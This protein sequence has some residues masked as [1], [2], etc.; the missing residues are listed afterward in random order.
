MSDV[1]PLAL[2]GGGPGRRAALSGPRGA[3]EAVMLFGELSKEL[4]NDGGL[5]GVAAGESV[6]ADAVALEGSA[7]ALSVTLGSCAGTTGGLSC[8]GSSIV[9]DSAV[10]LCSHCQKGIQ[11]AKFVDPE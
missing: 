9:L 7:N 2:D 3:E 5:R 4:R 1:K 11:A 8:R 10:G 6:P